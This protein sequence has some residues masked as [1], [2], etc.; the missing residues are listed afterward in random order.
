MNLEIYM[1]GMGMVAPFKYFIKNPSSLQ[2]YPKLHTPINSLF[3]IAQM[4]LEH[5]HYRT[6]LI[7][8]FCRMHITKLRKLANN[9][10]SVMFR[11]VKTV[12]NSNQTRKDLMETMFPVK[13][14]ILQP[15]LQVRKRIKLLISESFCAL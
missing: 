2:Q 11:V 13:K 7:E 9:N 4:F 1:Q 15:S 6:P 14:F 8:C 10:F 3:K 5:I 12:V